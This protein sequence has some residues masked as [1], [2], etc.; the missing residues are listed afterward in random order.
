M[1]ILVLERNSQHSRSY[2]INGG[3]TKGLGILGE[4]L[5]GQSSADLRN[6]LNDPGNRRDGLDCNDIRKRG[7]GLILGSEFGYRTELRFDKDKFANLLDQWDAVYP[8]LP[9]KILITVDKKGNFTVTPQGKL[10]G[11]PNCNA[12]GFV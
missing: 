12:H 8:K 10:N 4:I 1:R 6:F 2:S 11:C 7:N 3:E 9:D 5:L